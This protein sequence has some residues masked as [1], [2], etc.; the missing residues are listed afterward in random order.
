MRDIHTTLMGNATADPTP[1]QHEDGTTS[2]SVRVAVTSRYYDS[3]TS[4]FADRKTEFITV[5]T[6]KALARNLLTSV[7]KGNPLVVTGRLGLSEWVADDGASRHS[8]TLQ[9][10]ALGHDL[11]FGAASFARPLK[12]EDVPEHDPQ[13]G[14]ILSPN[15]EEDSVSPLTDEQS[16]DDE[17]A[18]AF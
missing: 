11:T 18:P 9:A 4:A 6:R 3:S 5:F 2:A 15:E 8:L 16:E 13:S 14:E 12:A 7:K 10:E 17:L 1:R